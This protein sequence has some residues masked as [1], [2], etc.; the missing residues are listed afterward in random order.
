MTERIEPVDKPTIPDFDLI[1]PIGQGAFGVVWLAKNQTTER[2]RAVKV[3]PRKKSGASDPAGREIVSITRL[4][5]N[6]KRRHEHLIEIQHVGQTDDHLFY[7]MELADNAATGDGSYKPETL[8]RRL[9]E[10]PLAT[11]ELFDIAEQLLKAIAHLHA[12]G[13]VHRDVKPSN[14]LFVD[15]K[16]KLAD[17][18]LLA[19]AGPLVSR[20][21]TRTY[22]PPDGRM[23]ARADVY[24]AGL[25]I[26]EMMTGFT[27]DCFP[28]MGKRGEQLADDL[29][30]AAVQMVVLRAC[31][32]SR[33]ERFADGRKMLNA[34]A[35][36][37]DKLK[38]HG[39][40][41]AVSRTMCGL[42][43]AIVLAVCA[44]VGPMMLPE[45]PSGHPDSVLSPKM[46]YVAA[47]FITDPF[48]AEI[49]I[50]GRL[51]TD[52]KGMPYKTPCT[53]ADIVPR[54]AAVEFIGP[55]GRT[56]DLGTVDFSEAREVEA[57]W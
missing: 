29:D 52:E 55:H 30:L 56:I 14:C 31:E 46:E 1:R 39:H 25:V 50:D 2:E 20:I 18:G 53:V 6:V 17:F 7:V 38:N 21:G 19:D 4:E 45:K 3:V 11:E 51:M 34:L 43:A 13:V 8:E 54:P 32:S 16:L 28:R 12:S 9:R 47:T 48:E 40:G 49:R 22:M 42:I 36:T 57:S 33:S 24:A 23:D 44:F 27:A 10:G 5:E 35:A 15:G 37:R 41:I 26:Y